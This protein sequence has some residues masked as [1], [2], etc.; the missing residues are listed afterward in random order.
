MSDFNVWSYFAKLGVQGN[1][2]RVKAF[3]RIERLEDS[4]IVFCI[5]RMC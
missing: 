1:E 4:V 5:I 3:L 2:S